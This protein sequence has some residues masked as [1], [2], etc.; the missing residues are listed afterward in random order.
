MGMEK[1]MHCILPLWATVIFFNSTGANL[2]Y[3]R[4]LNNSWESKVVV[5]MTW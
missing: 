4:K 3:L 1:A 2:T 5:A